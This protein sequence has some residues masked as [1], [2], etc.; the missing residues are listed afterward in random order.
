MNNAIWKGL[1]VLTALLLAATPGVRTRTAEAAL[2]GPEISDRLR[3]ADKALRWLD[4]RQNADGGFGDA[5]SDPRTTCEVVLAFASA[6]EQPAT[7]Q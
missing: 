1:A 2:S 4:A 5:G 3:A 6:Y 7:V